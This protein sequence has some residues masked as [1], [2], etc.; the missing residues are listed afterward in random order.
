MARFIVITDGYSPE[1]RL[2]ADRILVVEELDHDQFRWVIELPAEDEAL[3]AEAAST[4]HIERAEARL[5][6]ASIR[7]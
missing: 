1:V 5:T 3:L 2:L 7:V 4:A 6:V